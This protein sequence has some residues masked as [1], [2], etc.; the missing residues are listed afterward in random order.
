M[1][2][3]GGTQ[4]YKAQAVTLVESLFSKGKGF[5]RGSEKYGDKPHHLPS[6]P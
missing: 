1:V 4:E 6:G 5:L 2:P 3:L